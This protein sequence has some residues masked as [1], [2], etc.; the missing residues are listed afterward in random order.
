[1]KDLVM[2]EAEFKRELAKQVIDEGFFEYKYKKYDIIKTTGKCVDCAFGISEGFE[3]VC[4]VPSVLNG[5]CRC[6]KIMY[7][8]RV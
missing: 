8:E 2:I 5:A 1:M 7:K 3:V 4:K 6:H